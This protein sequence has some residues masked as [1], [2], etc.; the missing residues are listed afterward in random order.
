MLWPP[1]VKSCLIGK[2]PDAGKDG[3]QR[4]KGAEKMR[5]LDSITDSVDMNLNKLWEREE[6]RGAWCA[7]V[8]GIQ[9]LHK[10]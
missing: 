4:E 7:T 10:T 8:H 5:W 3:R 9:E 6:D 1:E 2:D